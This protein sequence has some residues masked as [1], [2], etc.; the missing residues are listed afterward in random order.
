MQ[1]MLEEAKA[2]LIVTH[3]MKIVKKVCTRA[4]LMDRGRIIFDGDPLE[5]V[6]IYRTSVKTKKEKFKWGC[7]RC[8]I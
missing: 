3:S 7:F 1:E 2:V 5:A 8:E 6:D 4:L